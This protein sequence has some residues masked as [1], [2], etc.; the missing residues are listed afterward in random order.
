MSVKKEHSDEAVEINI[1]GRR[2]TV[3]PGTHTIAS[4]IEDGAVDAG[5]KKLTLTGVP[6]PVLVLG[7]TDS[8][9]I[10]GGESFKTN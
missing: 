10:I 2:K 5:T 4:L 6:T 9:K 7:P 3:E 1:D 8:Y